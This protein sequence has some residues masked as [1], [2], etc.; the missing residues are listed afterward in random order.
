MTANIECVRCGKQHVHGD[1]DG[2]VSAG[3]STANADDTGVDMQKDPPPIDYY[4]TD[5]PG[6]GHGV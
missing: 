3:Y 2:P 5:E 6:Y 4:P 1:C